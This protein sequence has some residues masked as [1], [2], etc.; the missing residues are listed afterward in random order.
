MVQLFFSFKCYHANCVSKIR[1]LSHFVDRAKFTYLKNY[2][3]ANST[4]YQSG[5]NFTPH[6]LNL[7]LKVEQVTSDS[8]GFEFEPYMPMSLCNHDLSIMCHCH[9]HWCHC[10]H[11]W[12][13]LYTAVPVT[14][15]L[16]ET[17]Y[18]ADTCIYI[19]SICT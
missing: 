13:C 19:P 14:A 17:L 4:L 11:H 12:C 8:E 6:S 3:T 10:C 5:S 2:N 18:L 16:I 9:H 15:L 7:E 1:E